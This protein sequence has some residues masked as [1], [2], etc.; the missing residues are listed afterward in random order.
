MNKQEI[1]WKIDALDED[2]VLVRNAHGDDAN[3]IEGNYFSFSF[4]VLTQIQCCDGV[5]RNSLSIYY[6]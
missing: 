5:L 1:N 6:S 4:Q 2:K 3:E